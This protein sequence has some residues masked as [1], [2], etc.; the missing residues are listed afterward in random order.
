MNS[1]FQ[2]LSNIIEDIYI[3]NSAKHLLVVIHAVILKLMG[4][5]ELKSNDT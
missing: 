2:I 4:H 3:F 1:L 5:L